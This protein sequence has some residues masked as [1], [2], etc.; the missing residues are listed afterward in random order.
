MEENQV[1]QPWQMEPSCRTLHGLRSKHQLTQPRLC[2]LAG[3]AAILTD[4]ERV[5]EQLGVE[6]GFPL[7]PKTIEDIMLYLARKDKSLCKNLYQ[8]RNGVKV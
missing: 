3:M 2:Q 4:S 6:E 8:L 5:V 1:E 7:P